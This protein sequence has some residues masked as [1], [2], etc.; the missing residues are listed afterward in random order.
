MIGQI[1]VTGEAIQSE[2]PT[3]LQRAAMAPAGAG[4]GDHAHGG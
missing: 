3:V 1:I 2:P 4:T